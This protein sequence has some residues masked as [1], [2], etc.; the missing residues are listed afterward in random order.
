M[1][2]WGGHCAPH[3]S[4]FQQYFYNAFLLCPGHRRCACT[5]AIFK[6]FDGG[7]EKERPCIPL[8]LSGCQQQW[9][10]FI[11]KEQ[12]SFRCGQGIRRDSQKSMS[13]YEPAG[14]G[15]RKKE[16]CIK[17]MKKRLYGAIKMLFVPVKDCMYS[18]IGRF[19]GSSD[20]TAMKYRIRPGSR[21]W[22]FLCRRQAV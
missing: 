18:Y 2:W 4:G 1:L 16:Y 21:E 12:L 10:Y 8:R 11:F 7:T 15:L 3:R 20:R 14:R 22:A 13:D 17:C 9:G 19:H 5:E 6:K